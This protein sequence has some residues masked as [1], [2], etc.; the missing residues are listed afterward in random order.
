M[1]RRLIRD[2]ILTSDRIDSLDANAERFYYRLLLVVD[3]YARFSADLRI[4]RSS[5]FPLKDDI[6]TADIARWLAACE[7]A[8]LVRLYMVAGKEYL[9]IQDFRQT[10]RAK[11][12]KFPPPPQHSGCDTDATHMH[13]TRTA[14]VPEDGDEDEDEDGNTGRGAPALP[15][16]VTISGYPQN[17]DEVLQMASDPRCAVRISREQAE[18]Y[19]LTRDTADWFDAA[20][21]KIQP[22]KVFGD[23]RKWMLREQGQGGSNGE[24]GARRGGRTYGTPDESEFEESWGKNGN[25]S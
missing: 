11:E 2:G 4:L 5:V 21:R 24:R 12:S 10:I 15:P 7:K 16:P 14:H 9:E 6:R 1:P 25:Q 13:R 23:I 8:G 18:A 22:G 3:D 19:F 17:V 20:R